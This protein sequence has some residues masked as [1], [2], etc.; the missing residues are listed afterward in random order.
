METT[1]NYKYRINAKGGKLKKLQATLDTC[2]LVYNKVLD[3]RKT[4]WEQEK[5]SLRV[6]DCHNLI[7]T[8]DIEGVHSQVLQNVS[9]RVDLAFQGFFR[10]VK[11]VGEK[12]GYPRFKGFDR[13]D[14]FCF[15]QSGFKLLEGGKKLFLS[16]VGDVKVNLHRELVGKVKTC[17]IKRECDD[18]YVIFACKV[19]KE[20]QVKYETKAVGIDVGC[21]DFATMSD[22]DTITNPHFLRQSDKEL[23]DTQRK[24][25]KLK[26]LPKDDK[27]KIKVKK[28]LVKLHCKVKNQRKDF[29]HKLSRK[30]VN[31]Y[32][33]ICV[34]KL[35]VKEMLKDNWRALNKSIIDSGWT[36]FRNMLNYKAEEAGSLVVEVNPA[37]TSQ[38]CSGCGVKVKKE[39][40]DRIHRCDTCGLE[41]GRDL[42][43]AKNILRVGMDSLRGRKAT[44]EAH[45]L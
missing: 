29:L 4:A 5:K 24:Y 23:K 37:Y 7:K 25:S 13:Y 44:L 39:L 10:R 36:T 17:T 31:D 30:I 38:I 3:T 11:Q 19:E 21:I 1:R 45:T 27:K 12:A 32:S 42:N 35:K 41:I 33:V 15:P 20:P 34:E 18:W 14:S 8:W 22:G 43:A 16:K 2:R 26:Q 28:K 9:A 6:Y 40:S